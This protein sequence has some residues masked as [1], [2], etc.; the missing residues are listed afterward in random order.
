MRKKIR[1][2]IRELFSSSCTR[3]SRAGMPNG[4]FFNDLLWFGDSESKE[5]AVARGFIIE[6]GELDVLDGGLKADL[7]S[8]LQTLLGT[9]GDGYTA[10]ARFLAGCDY[11]DV[12]GGYERD[13]KAIS[14][15]VR[16]KWQV[17]ART[18]RHKRHLETMQ[19][20]KLRRDAFTLFF[21][22]VIEGP[23]AF[24]LSGKALRE[25]FS[26]LARREAASFEEVQG[27]A[28]RTMFPEARVR[29]M[30]DHEHYL[31][32]YRFLNP[33]VGATIPE[34]VFEGY[35]PSLSIQENC[36]FGDVVQHPIP[37]I[38]FSFD[39]YHH[40]LLVMRE[41]PRQ[42]GA[43]MITRL[44]NLGLKEG[45]ADFELSVSLYPR[46]TER[47]IRDFE[48]VANQLK[49]EVNTKPKRAASLGTQAAMADERIAELER[50]TV[51]PFD[52]FFAL[53][54]WHRDPETVISRAEIAR[55]AFT[56]LSG[57][58]AYLATNPETA[59]QLWFQTW[60]G[61]THG[62]YRGYDLTTDD[63]TAAE[64]IP[65]S[66]TFSGRL[67][68]AEALYENAKGGLV[69]VSTQV[70]GVPQP[71]LVFGQIGAGKSILMTDFWAQIAHLFGYKLVLEEG[72]DH[73]ITVQTAGCQPIIVTPNS[74]LSINYLDPCGLPL[75]PEHRGAA[76]GL[77]L[78]M[79][80]ENVGPNVDE[81]RVSVF[82]GQLIDHLNALYDSVW[83]DWVAVHAEEAQ[84]I[85]R[86]AYG[87]HCMSKAQDLAQRGSFV[88][89]WSELRDREAQDPEAVAAFLEA[90]DEGEVSQFQTHPV[91]RGFVRDLGF[92]YLDPE[93]M[94]RHA[95]LVE[96]MRWTPIG[97]KR[98]NPE[99]VR[100]GE[101]L[102][103]WNA[104]GQY[105]PLFDGVT[106]RRLD[107]DTTHFDLHSIPPSMEEM[108]AAAHYL[109]LNA[110]RQ[111]VIKRPRAERKLILF[112]EGAR[113][114][115]TPG[116]A[117][118]LREFY[119]QMR[120]FNVCVGTVFQQ[121]S[122][123]QDAGPAVRAAI[124]DNTKLFLISAQPSPAA[125]ESISDSLE[126]SQAAREAIKH[127]P[128]PE[129]QTGKVKYSSFLM[130][131]AHPT[132]R[133]IG[134]LRNISSPKVVYCGQ[135]NCDTFDK[136]QKAL[137]KYPDIVEGILAEAPKEVE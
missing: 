13:T 20:G 44:S 24:S 37:G 19:A 28:L 30:T 25:H 74:G 26:G 27:T 64:L 93:E 108:K 103:T 14:D 134:T 31:H 54:L 90:L 131:A 82:R 58:V 61:W 41:L 32:Y 84:R 53:R 65:W 60:P 85:A 67:D 75:S 15:P 112:E 116:G 46:G 89:C 106:T 43:G 86:R 76:V 59:R 100:I 69:G 5:V 117:T 109:I 48:A 80:R 133:L 114:L 123:L 98:N 1:R 11:S 73:A 47:A 29:V 136:K 7:S 51:R 23:P 101:R 4:F 21:C 36:L 68:G 42:A 3:I 18:E 129:H 135:S 33:R 70:G 104:D 50:G 87:I 137:A 113:L 57:S 111:Q 91:T 81:G 122:A 71:F 22:R 119:A 72:L 17:Y 94:P 16:A 77:N 45:F 62:E 9:L 127:Y 49:G 66:G 132:R 120:K 118:V 107:A 34:T 63:L 6:P 115:Q 97:G 79:L 38:S 128:L 40:A 10:Q 99:A 78:L 105:G 126:L 12:L 125:A 92:A 110:S 35:D 102:S 39:G 83:K 130:V 52:V 8:R 124:V 88:D 121:A 95:Q 55:N 2:I 56:S 96:T